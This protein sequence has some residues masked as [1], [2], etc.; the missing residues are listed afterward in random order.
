[1]GRTGGACAAAKGDCTRVI[2][3][4]RATPN[5][6]AT[7]RTIGRL[8]DSGKL[9]AFGTRRDRITR[10]ELD[11][12]MAETPNVGDGE[13]DVAGEVER[14]LARRNSR[15]AMPATKRC[16]FLR[17]GRIWTIVY[18]GPDGR[19][20]QQA[21]KFRGPEQEGKARKALALFTQRVEAGAG[22]DVGTDGPLTVARW[23]NQWVDGRAAKGVRTDEYRSRL[24][25]HILPHIGHLRL[26]K[27]TPEHVGLVLA[28]VRKPLRPVPSVTSTG[29]CTR[30][31]ARR[32]PACLRP[33]R[34][35][36][37]SRTCPAKRTQTSSGGR[38]PS[39]RGPR[40]NCCSP[41]SASRT[42]GAR[43]T[44]SSSWRGLRF[45]E[46]SALCVRH[47]R[48]ELESLGQLQVAR[49]FDSR[50]R[51]IKDTKTERPRNVP[52]HPW[53]RKDLL[54]LVAHGPE[55][56]I[57]DIYTEMTWAPLCA[58]V[59]KLRLGPGCHRVAMEENMHVIN[60]LGSDPSG[61]RKPSRPRERR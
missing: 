3:W 19:S 23:A 2:G 39:S 35:G 12:M 11:R 56:D 20:R 38:P 49:S 58:E 42:T 24:E 13:D 5:A 50:R 27:I 53:A 29:R 8:I 46:A 36:A 1:M 47:Y 54:R 37:M 40:S 45:G 57:V 33:T 22:L 59:A 48:L 43:S 28:A 18:P 9:R 52:V 44:P 61:I 7:V 15:P 60:G 10:F 26:D 34:A 4:D 51:R 17:R 21:T 32:C 6:L 31:S 41:T 16:L 25:R 30:C 14:L 55:G